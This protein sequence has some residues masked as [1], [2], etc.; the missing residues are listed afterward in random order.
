MAVTI[1]T[2]RAAFTRRR[3]LT[4]AASSAAIT[5]AGGIAKPS[6]SHVADRPAIT[7]GIQSG[8]VSIDSGVVWARADRPSRMLVEAATTDSFKTIRSAVAVDALAGDRFHRQGAARRTC[9]PDRTSSTAS[10]SR[11]TPSR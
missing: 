6:I 2:R 9:R 3:F 7:H 8:D 1:L 11:I 10:G 5:V 4:T